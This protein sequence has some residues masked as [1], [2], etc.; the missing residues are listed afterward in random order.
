[1]LVFGK[2]KGE[3]YHSRTIE[4][5]TFDYDDERFVIEG[6][7]T[8]RRFRDYQIVSGD[9]KPPGILHQMVIHLLVDKKS[10]EI[11]DI[12]VAMPVA[13]REECRETIDCLAPA[14]G[15]RVAG[16]FTAKIKDMAGGTKGCNH[17]VAL[18]TAMGPAVFQGYGSYWN[19][20]RPGHLQ[21]H[22]EL[23]LNTCRTWREDGPLVEDLR[24]QRELRRK[25][26]K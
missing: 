15:L 6:T 21:D 10:L 5:A 20:K 18:M 23:L 4:T 11:E 3:K 17:L 26:K 22:F 8:D 12:E 13:P 16:G 14:K 7:L 24:K 2:P 19:H 1:M 9:R 25:E